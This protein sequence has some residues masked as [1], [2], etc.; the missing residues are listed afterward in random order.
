MKKFK[1]TRI[2]HYSETVEVECVDLE[3]ANE[4]IF[5][6]EIEFEHNN[7]DYL[8]DSSIEYLGGE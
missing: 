1:L 7:D 6:Y 2:M 5:S 4:L 3:E 8:Y